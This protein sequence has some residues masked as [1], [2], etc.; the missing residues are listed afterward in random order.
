V[1]L[2]TFNILSGRSPGDGE[3]HPERLAGAV[4]GLAPDVLGLQ[5]VDRSL[6]RSGGVDLTEVAAEAMGARWSR[7]LPAL[8]G[9]P[10]RAGVVPGVASGAAAAAGEPGGAAG[11]PGGAAGEPGYGIALLSRWPASEFRE[12]RLPSLPFPVPLFLGN[13][14]RWVLVR[15]EPRVGLAAA[16]ESPVGPLTVA[17]T[18]L[19]FIPGWNAVQLRR[20]AVAVR[21][22]P[23]PRLLLG[24]LNTGRPRLPGWRVLAR[25]HTYPAS[26][27]GRQLD[28]V[29]AEGVGADV[30]AARAVRCRLSDHLAL[31]VDVEFLR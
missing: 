31:V 14:R 26:P 7:F 10:G 22:L 4:A 5:E 16:I 15:D 27:P 9:A 6:E 11:T 3:V 29:L 1:R 25:A 19:S 30:R 13:P 24:D 18:H 2:V 20:L 8:P 28:H 23:G 17:N 12:V 21:A